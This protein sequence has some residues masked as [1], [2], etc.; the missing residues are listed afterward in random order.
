MHDASENGFSAVIR[1]DVKLLL[2]AAASLA[3]A[4]CA[5]RLAHYDGYHG[6]GTFTPHPAPNWTCRDGYTVDLGPIDLA[7]TGEK[8]QEL[9]GL[10]SIEAIVGVAV[11]R[12]PD[13]ADDRGEVLA[14]HRPAA[15]I[16]ITL[17]DARGHIVLSRRERLTQW[18]GSRVFD[19][20]GHA[21]LFQRGT[22]TEI[23]VAPGV[24]R[25]ERFPI[26]ADD[27]WGTYFTPRRDARYT[28]HFAV[29]EPDDPGDVDVRL[30]VRAVA[31]CP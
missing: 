27:S 16:E 22:E 13:A 1:V 25:V 30:Q 6:D 2:A 23:P 14:T 15:L 9:A 26:G 3:V 5:P 29:E 19:D 8:T 31:G 28:L 7:G 4:A 21:F 24:V 20:P 11:E 10:P 18:I 12:K 17:R